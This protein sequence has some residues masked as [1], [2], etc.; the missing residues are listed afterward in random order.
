MQFILNK[1]ELGQ[2]IFYTGQMRRLNIPQQT[3]IPT[4]S[5]LEL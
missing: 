5:Y 3:V 2:N 1:R 4:I